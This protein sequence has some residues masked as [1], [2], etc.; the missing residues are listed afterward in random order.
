[1]A[2]RRSW[3]GSGVGAFTAADPGL[4]RGCISN[5]RG[6][7]EIPQRDRQAL[8][9]T[10]GSVRLDRLFGLPI[11]RVLASS[12]ETVVPL[13]S[14]STQLGVSL[15]RILDC[16]Q[17]DR[18]HKFFIAR[19]VIPCRLLAWR[20]QLAIRIEQKSSGRLKNPSIGRSIPLDDE[21][22]RG[23]RTE[24]FLGPDNSQFHRPHHRRNWIILLDCG[25]GGD[26]PD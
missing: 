3:C 7:R 12:F 21:W 19:R 14:Q 10:A 17:H 16:R 11:Q 24:T 15:G 2:I 18:I 23:R 8:G 5:R 20:V 26:S 6:G 25:E 9:T 22:T 4:G 13:C 1:M